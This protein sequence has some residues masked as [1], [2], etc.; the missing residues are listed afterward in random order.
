[1]RSHRVVVL[2]PAFDN[3]LRLGQRV[4]DLPVQQLVAQLAVEALAIAVL[5]GTTGIDERRFRA[6]H[7]NP[8]P[9]GPDDEF[10]AIVRADMAWPP[11]QDE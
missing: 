10:R 1:M 8:L 2:T 6:H 4:E 3:D 11:T 7:S 9:Y 5:P